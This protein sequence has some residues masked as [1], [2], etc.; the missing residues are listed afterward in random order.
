MPNWGQAKP[1]LAAPPAFQAQAA[2]AAKE[3]LLSQFMI[4]NGGEKTRAV[5]Q[6]E[7]AQSFVGAFQRGV[8]TDP[9]ECGIN[10]KVAIGH[11]V[12]GGGIRGDQTVQTMVV[13]HGVPQPD[14][15]APNA[16]CQAESWI[17]NRPNLKVP[18]RLFR[19]SGKVN[20]R[21]DG[22]LHLIQL[23]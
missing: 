10:G 2:D 14:P 1:G 19:R 21:D 3:A 18:A 23:P 17:A 8:I 22:Q 7:S 20:I 6:A 5:G 12:I 16:G 4:T 15:T 11:H 13:A 9:N